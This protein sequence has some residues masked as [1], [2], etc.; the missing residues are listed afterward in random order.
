MG[1]GVSSEPE[2]TVRGQAPQSSNSQRPRVL[3]PN[4]SEFVK[5]GRATIKQHRE[6]ENRNSRKMRAAVLGRRSACTVLIDKNGF[7]V[8]QLRICEGQVVTFK[9][10]ETSSD[11]QGYNVTQVVHDGEKFKPVIG[12]FHSGQISRKGF[13]EEQFNLSG[14]YKFVS[15][16]IKC[17]PL[18][19]EVYERTNI[20]AELGDEG[21]FP[22][23]LRIDEGN[24]IE[25]RW[26]NC[27]IPHS[28]TEVKYFHRWGKFI[29]KDDISGPSSRSG[30]CKRSFDNPGLFYFQSEG[31]SPGEKIFCGVHSQFNREH[32]IEILDNEFQP[33]ILLID[34]G[35]RVWWG[36]DKNRTKK[37]HC[38][39]EIERPSANSRSDDSYKQKKN[40]FQWPK[41]SKCGLLS[42][43]F[44][45]AGV[46]YF[47]DYNATQAAEYVGTI[48]VK[49]KEKEHF[50]ELSRNDQFS[51]GLQKVKTGDRVWF[52]WKPNE[53]ESGFLLREWEKCN[54]IEATR[55]GIENDNSDINE[56]AYMD[57]ECEKLKAQIGVDTVIFGTVGVYHY[58]VPDC[59]DIINSC[60]IICENGPRNYTVH[61]TDQGFEPK[62][63]TVKAGDR[64]WWI[65]QESSRKALPHNIAQVTHSGNVIKTGFSSG[66]LLDTP[67]G[68]V[69]RFENLG[70]YYYI[71]D[72]LP[73]AFGAVVVSKAPKVHEVE[74]EPGESIENDPVVANV[75]DVVAWTY[76]GLQHYDVSQ[77]TSIEHLLDPQIENTEQG[78]RYCMNR[79]FSKKGMYHFT[80]RGFYNYNRGARNSLEDQ[81]VSTVLVDHINE[82]AQI[83]VNSK[84]FW[85]PKI[86]IQKGQSIL[87][88][89]VGSEEAHNIIH[90]NNSDN[91][92]PLS[93][94]QGSKAFNSGKQTPNSSFLHTFD[95]C[96]VFSVISQGAPG[97]P[98]EVHVL[99]APASKT[100]K[101]YIQGGEMNGGTV[102]KNHVVWLKCDTAGAKIY[103]T[104]DGTAPELHK[105]NVKKYDAKKGITLKN[106][107]LH[108][109][110]A[111]A[112]SDNRINST[113]LTSK[114]F[115]VT[116]DG[117]DRSESNSE[118]EEDMDALQKNTE[119]W[120]NCVPNIKSH[121]VGP[122]VIE[123]F[124]ENP[125]LEALAELKGY[126]VL[127]NDISYGKEI[128]PN[129][130]SAV[131]AD[132]AADR[133][134]E[135]VLEA[136]P[137]SRHFLSHKSNKLILKCPKVVETGGP[138][139]SLEVAEKK[140]SIAVVWKSISTEDSPIEYYSLY[141]NGQKC[142]DDIRPGDQM[143]RC[144]IVIDGCQEN[145]MYRVILVAV[146]KDGRQH[147]S[148]ELDVTLP[149]VINDIKLPPHDARNYDDDLYKEYVEVQEGKATITKREIRYTSENESNDEEDDTNLE[150][151]NDSQNN[152]SNDTENDEEDNYNHYPSDARSKNKK[153]KNSGSST[154]E[155]TRGFQEPELAEE[156]VE[157][158]EEQLRGLKAEIRRQSL[159]EKSEDD[160]EYSVQQK[161]IRGLK[162]ETRRQSLIEKSD[163]DT[164][165]SVPS[166]S[167]EKQKERNFKK[168][169][170]PFKTRPYSPKMNEEEDE[171]NDDDDDDEEE[172]EDD[173]DEAT[174]EREG[175]RVWQEDGE[176]TESESEIR[177]VEDETKIYSDYGIMSEVLRSSSH[178]DKV[179]KLK[180]NDVR[181]FQIANPVDNNKTVY[182]R[183]VSLGRPPNWKSITEKIKTVSLFNTLKKSREQNI[184]S[185]NVRKSNDL[186]NPPNDNYSERIS[187]CLFDKAVSFRKQENDYQIIDATMGPWK[188]KM[189]PAAKVSTLITR[190]NKLIPHKNEVVV[191]EDKSDTSEQFLVEVMS[192]AESSDD[193]V[194]QRDDR[195]KKP[196]K[197]MK[198]AKDTKVVV[199]ADNV[200]INKPNDT[201]RVNKVTSQGLPLQSSNKTSQ[202]SV[203]SELLPKPRIRA[204]NKGENRVLISWEV[205]ESSDPKMRLLVYVVHVLGRRFLKKVNSSM[206]Y[207]C[208]IE[209]KKESFVGVHHIWNITSG[210]LECEVS[211]LFP[212]EEYRLF[213]TAHYTRLDS[214]HSAE[215]Q[216]QSEILRYTAIG[217]LT[218]PT[219]NIVSTDVYQA[220]IEWA[221]DINQRQ[222]ANIVGYHIFIDEKRVGEQ[223]KSSI[224]QSLIDNLKPGKA[225]RVNIRSYSEKF[226]ESANSNTVVIKCPQKPPAP[227]VVQ[228]PAFSVGKAIVSWTRPQNIRISERGE[229]ILFYRVFVDNDM[230]G[231]VRSSS[232]SNKAGYQFSCSKLAPGK[233]YDLVVRAYAG[234]KINSG[235]QVNSVYCLAESDDTNMIQV[236]CSAPPESPT[237]HI[238]SMDVD[239]IDVGWEMPQ[240]YGDAAVSGFQMIKDD[241]FYG[242]IMPSDVYS[243]RI[244][245]GIHLGD[246][247]T[248]QILALTDHP[249]GRETDA[250][251]SSQDAISSIP[252]NDI[253]LLELY[254]GGRYKACKLGPKLTIWYTGLVSPP[255]KVH[256]ENVTGH[257]AV[258][259]W[260]IST[261]EKKHFVA[262]ENYIVTWWPGNDAKEHVRS[263]TTTNDH[264]LLEDLKQNVKYT[265]IVEARRI[266]NYADTDKT[267]I[268]SGKSEPL[269]VITA[270]PPAPI[271]NMGIVATTNSAIK[272]KWD[273][274]QATGV[275]IICLRVDAVA[276]RPIPD[277]KHSCTEVTPDS[278]EAIVENL[279]E[280]TEY[281]ISVT[282]VTEEYF[283]NLPS[284][285]PLRVHHAFPKDRPPPEDNWLPK[286][287]MTGT[288][289]GT[290]PPFDVHAVNITPTSI[291]VSWKP[292]TVYGSCR[293]QGTLLRWAIAKNVSGDSEEGEMANYSNMSVDSER[294]TIENLL[295]GV[296]YKIVVE[297]IVSAKNAV[298]STSSDHPEAEKMDRRTLHVTS[299]PVVIRTKAPCEPP[300]IRM[301]GFTPSTIDIKWQKPVLTR[302]VGKNPYGVPDFIKLNLECYRLEINDK[303]HM[304]LSPNAQACTLT[305]CKPGKRYKI[306]LVAITCPEDVKKMRKKDQKKL[307]NVSVKEDSMNRKW[308][309]LPI[310][311]ENDESF[312]NQIIETLPVEQSGLLQTC[313]IEFVPPV[314]SG[315]Q[316]EMKLNWTVQ[317]STN[318]LEQFEI[319]WIDGKGQGNKKTVPAS[320][321]EVLLPVTGQSIIQDV[322]IMPILNRGSSENTAQVV[323]C[324]LP[325]K[326]DPPVIYSKGDVRSDQFT[327]E[328]GEP[329]LWGHNIVN[330]LLYLNGKK[331][332][333]ELEARHRK[334]TIPCSISKSY[335]VQLQAVTANPDI[336]ASDLSNVLEIIP[337]HGKVIP[338]HAPVVAEDEDEV[339]EDYI[340]LIVVKVTDS[341][342]HLDWSRYL[343]PS[344]SHYKLTWSSVANPGDKDVELRPGEKSCTI[345]KCYQGTNHF[346]KLTAVDELGQI[347][348][349]SKQLT[350]QTSAP[351]DAPNLSLRAKNFKYITIEWNR[352][353]CYGEG[354][355]IEY[356][357]FINGI[358]E[359]KVGP[360]QFH[361]S[362]TRGYWCS[363]YA[364]QVQA[365]TG[366]DRLD[367]RPSDPLVVIW[368][369]VQ[370][371]VL[372]RVPAVGKSS[373]RIVW[374]VPITTDGIDIKQ[375][376]LVCKDEETGNIAQ[377][378]APIHPSTT[379]A[380]IH[381]LKSG[382]YQVFL[383]VHV[384]GT[385]EVVRSDTLRIVPTISPDPPNVSV[386]VVG[387][388]ERR[389]VEKVT[390][391]LINKRDRLLNILASGAS[392]EDFAVKR[393][394]EE[395]GQIEHM[396]SDC[397]NSLKHNTGHVIAHMSWT[398]PQS[399]PDAI[400]SGFKVLVD[401]K[402]YG[403]TL[404]AGANNVRVK[405]GV[406]KEKHKLS[407]VAVCDRPK[408]LSAQSN[409]I[410]LLTE[411]FLPFSFFS[412]LETIN[413][414]YQETLAVEKRLPITKAINVGLLRRQVQPPS[415]AVLDI[416][417]CEFRTLI[418]P[419]GPRLPTALLFWSTSNRY[420]TK[421]LSW[422]V[423]YAR[424]NS[425]R[426]EFI[427]VS[428]ITD[429]LTDE[430][431]QNLVQ[432][433]SDNGWRDEQCVRHVTSVTSNSPSLSTTIVQKGGT[434]SHHI[435]HHDPNCKFPHNEKHESG[436]VTSYYGVQG[437]PS[438]VIIHPDDYISWK[439]RYCAF[440]YH[441][442]DAFITFILRQSINESTAEDPWDKKI[443]P[444]LFSSDLN[445]DTTHVLV[446]RKDRS[447]S[448]TGTF[449]T[450]GNT[451]TIIHAPSI[452]NKKSRPRSPKRLFQK[453]YNKKRSSQKI[454]VENRPFSAQ[455]PY[456]QK[457]LDPYQQI[458]TQSKKS[459]KPKSIY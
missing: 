428:C 47:S 301:T 350:V 143:D 174:E 244:Q 178:T 257:S 240:Q 159:V 282:A 71:S 185:K 115:W 113:I 455:S 232:T 19:I 335:K 222:D 347:V 299:K 368:P 150:N 367:S 417:E 392:I 459:K 140:D 342:I 203:S 406:E 139:I 285:D 287:S 22:K 356:K 416:F 34:E 254:I 360:D 142:G 457:L 69:H 292:A 435:D 348:D 179:F 445:N 293:L 404:S 226:G 362:F 83:R 44:H 198:M 14:F 164:E 251:P 248:L 168:P 78:P 162:V 227:E 249:V 147:H 291:A 167:I 376:K 17:T 305:C 171:D 284:G 86:C 228:E 98:C 221:E 295:P 187:T 310:D 229:D 399:N 110:R 422:F 5:D 451:A 423:K 233:A 373:V 152:R 96:G 317:G 6:S 429:D 190:L 208:M 41:P 378:V 370:P 393:A 89:W 425:S 214:S 2:Q 61:V 100:S 402:K 135:V 45:E 104:V 377:I 243:M 453:S 321:R 409:I 120:K 197:K 21:F 433:I 56:H 338:G 27:L 312:S 170:L 265:V 346:V 326:P 106:S 130:C 281:L 374:N 63:V 414:P 43:E 309:T 16:G 90:V 124:W 318:H 88:S 194:K 166:K 160:A 62:L 322:K 68:F 65:W 452:N 384:H 354:K 132:L 359:E 267:F 39:Y 129:C 155:D 42:H 18:T 102:E 355:I 105:L 444:E 224:R 307:E 421:Q 442:F 157:Q 333:R 122:G 397:L 448:P 158:I 50:I 46:Y 426:Y 319:T 215:A 154:M 231:E 23:I 55:P 48:V 261:K 66:A 127:L 316:G 262:A 419:S 211:G 266:A 441:S 253:G 33:Q 196:K 436:D 396:L 313:N 49:P 458:H 258:I 59:P 29:A 32:Q 163:D 341:T 260:K 277:H 330:Y 125:P 73:K 383:E 144:R 278:V 219:L 391:D 223:L 412:F 290:E 247:I 1:C 218:A 133:S 275:D 235:Q 3:P 343:E 51:P 385:Q 119:N 40:G 415:C 126:K 72:S 188:N 443:E 427:A 107:G 207:E 273:S 180:A 109:I 77:I 149:L 250:A 206:S 447:H 437:V 186:A 213:V 31:L 136:I 173:D 405:L 327:I 37:L 372:Q 114:R 242:E 10:D 30:S 329:K 175:G 361:Y 357:I 225:V 81:R 280:K 337:S 388:E 94:V 381:N 306:V 8:Q 123:I 75:H 387:L 128:A 146:G 191:Q 283:S 323:Q 153:G 311:A 379:E 116:S 382:V 363:E 85:P 183:P 70:C 161:S 366:I 438:I 394:S 332:G 302:E 328:W 87:W 220:C 212:A 237:L 7:S 454:S 195:S 401:G 141:L 35:D 344:F 117:E 398:T 439:G 80:S 274:L 192:D 264:L 15:L 165:F 172:E 177:S 336:G 26:K 189:R 449:Q 432:T 52:T 440:D 256:A 67:S 182:Q 286:T 320:C 288:T 25:W 358:V 82:H 413:S 95:E 430:T 28:I 112:V 99:E 12:G 365:V 230:I 410:E 314:L 209:D 418:P 450:R 205:D 407:M 111:L 9:W 303:P 118:V 176:E 298:S 255:I 121:F 331:V 199:K 101:P 434:I 53:M 108:Y 340:P 390:C 269:S 241:R 276:L 259:A 325:G 64:I 74:V 279:A 151:K 308:T 380:E 371:P 60:S 431:R 57:Q 375:Y 216:V 97:F 271:N 296:Q 11:G 181:N 239:G 92:N 204:A 400:V 36:W 353:R 289:S 200:S 76:R 345:H 84:G 339:N 13:Y 4:K 93:R 315:D 54:T 245:E 395:L 324:L 156:L 386:N 217:Q 352:P 58:R 351:P 202:A 201:P 79:M 24:T 236:T 91:S 234:E 456:T 270:K 210:D 252:E 20:E 148:N 297:A 134:Y 38:V 137:K 411:P 184:L 408:S 268:L 334:A 304:R 389:Q 294:A 246:R 272:V 263:A 446:H 424:K 300:R 138:L 131:A 369:G 364:F 420:S 403:N 238:M 193:S 169:P 103:Y 145:N 349:Q